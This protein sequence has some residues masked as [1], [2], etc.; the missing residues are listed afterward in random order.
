LTERHG[1]IHFWGKMT[2]SLGLTNKKNSDV[3]SLKMYIVLC[4]CVL[5]PEGHRRRKD[6]WGIG[7]SIP[8]EDEI[9][10]FSAMSRLALGPS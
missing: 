5:M 4:Q 10:L 2:H 9:F 8:S 6:S 1:R 7:V 3:P